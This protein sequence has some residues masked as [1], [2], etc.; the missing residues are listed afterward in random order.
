MKSFLYVLLSVFSVGCAMAVPVVGDSSKVRFVQKSFG[1]AVAQAQREGKVI[2]FDAYTTWCGPCKQMD[3]EVFSDPRVADFFNEKMVSVKFDMESGEGPALKA[4]FDISAYP[5]FVFIA[6]DGATVLH[7]LVGYQQ[8]VKLLAEADRVLR[9]DSSLVSV[10]ERKFKSGDRNKEFLRQYLDVLGQAKELAKAE[11][12]ARAYLADVP[13]DQLIEKQNWEIFGKYINDP[14]DAGY[15]YFREHLPLFT[16]KYGDRVVEGK[17]MAVNFIYVRKKFF[18]RGEAEV[19]FDAKEFNRYMADLKKQKLPNGP[20]IVTELE[21]LKARETA[22]WVGYVTLVED[23]MKDGSLPSG[24]M[25][26]YNYALAIDRPAQVP[27]K[28]AFAASQWMA[29]CIAQSGGSVRSYQV[30]YAS[31][32]EK[33]GKHSE[34]EKVRQKMNEENGSK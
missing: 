26:V 17:L 3:R 9:Q 32:L 21:L 20:G 16:G 6:A 27:K 34:A 5:T 14:Y 10:L 24:G 1:E 2:F 7:K 29:K 18:P 11:D 4:R 31:L 25:A 30:L 33:S 12:V 13:A 23:G 28:C 22:D 8:G 19:A 15:Q